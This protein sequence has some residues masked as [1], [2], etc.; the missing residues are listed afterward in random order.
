MLSF[1]SFIKESEN[2]VATPFNPLGID[3]LRKDENRV[4]TFIRKVREGESFATTRYGDAIIDKKELSAVTAFMTADAGKLPANR[5]S[6][7]VVTNK[8]KLKVP[9]DFL[10]SGDF[11]GK[12]KGSGVSKETA[13]MN[14][15]NEELN[16][17]LQKEGVS[18]IKLSINKRTV[19]CA[20]MQKTVGKYNGKE[21]KSD[22]TIVDVNGKATAYISHKAGTSAKDYQQYGGVSD[23]ALPQEYRGNAFIKKFM[24]D[25]RALR[26]LG[27]KS[28]DSFYRKLDDDKLIRIMMYGPEYGGMPS[29]S[30]VDEF[31]LG[32]MNLVGRGEGPYQ[33]TSNHKGING[34][35]PTGAFE[36]VLFVR[37]QSARGDAR[38]G[39][40]V[41]KNARVG[42]FPIAKISS[43]SVQI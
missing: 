8:G 16:K 36:A 32:N 17:I 26:P 21:P 3:D 37:Y 41:V 19:K 13:A 31:H 18:Q 29:I 1:K 2:T 9:N 22:M 12:G 24:Q 33:I 10:K 34:Q 38:A 5:T 43:T 28:G 6:L 27:L 42:I 23:A 11:G 20:Y 30:N 39:G 40:E 4:L 25:V 14:Y 7:M 35:I 15:F